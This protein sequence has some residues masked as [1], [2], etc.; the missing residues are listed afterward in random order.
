M[1]PIFAIIALGFVA[2]R[3]I[4]IKPSWITFL[5]FC[6]YYVSLPALIISLFSKIE[7]TQNTIGFLGFH[8]GVIIIV[9]LLLVG[10]LSLLTIATKTKV[11]IV[12]GAMV[13][14]TV[15]M[16][17]PILRTTYPDFP[18]EVAMGAGTIQLIVGL[19]VS[20]FLI[21]YLIQKTK[22]F[23]TYFRDLVRD[24]LVI[25]VILGVILSFIPQSNT[26]DIFFKIVA[27]ISITASPLA[28][29]TLGVF[30]H[31]SFS[32]QSWFLGGFAILAKLV[33]FPIVVLFLSLIFGYSKEFTQ[34]SV[35]VSAMP[36]A[37]TSFVLAQKYSL[38]EELTADIILVST[39]L[40]LISMP[41]IVWLL[42]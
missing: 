4:S 18:I 29:F 5:N 35:V 34:I 3:Y 40:S 17:Y 30:M 33:L 1:L 21:E 22:K 31:R 9:S 2:Q 39:I 13:G 19:L 24:P 26:T 7:F 6:I 36:T 28:L 38:N 27:T 8:G 42:G 14:N 12:L 32:K 10:I 20:I 41:C 23:S 16:G 37:V 25:A 15:Y 11:A